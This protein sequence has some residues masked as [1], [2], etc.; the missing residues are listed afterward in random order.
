MTDTDTDNGRRL[1]HLPN[2]DREAWRRARSLYETEWE[3]IPGCP[4]LTAGLWFGALRRGEKISR[5]DALRIDRR[6]SRAI[7]YLETVQDTTP[8]PTK[9]ERAR[10][11][12]ERLSQVQ[13]DLQGAL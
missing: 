9:R 8:N 2:I 5:A 12:A 3:H 11:V 1:V 13:R 4:K 7:Q 6:L 10:D